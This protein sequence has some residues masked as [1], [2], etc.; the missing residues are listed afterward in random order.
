MR[1]I[2]FRAY[3]ST[4][5]MWDWDML[6]EHD[7]I[8]LK[9]L[10]DKDDWKVMQFTGLLDKNSKEIYEGDILRGDLNSE[11]NCVVEFVGGGF[12]LTG[13]E[14]EHYMPVEKHREVLGNIY[15]NPEL[16]NK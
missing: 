10:K 2:K 3:C 13:F 4:S 11:S 14:G 8:T 6:L 1:E 5:G 9:D 12:W 7:F 15:S 16:L